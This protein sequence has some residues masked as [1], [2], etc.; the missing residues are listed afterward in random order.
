MKK[1]GG[2]STYALL[3]IVTFLLTM[4]SVVIGTPLFRLIRN[5][6]GWL[7]YWGLGL[8]YCVLLSVV[9]AYPYTI[10]FSILW[11]TIGIYHELEVQG[12]TWK[13][14]SIL[15]LLGGIFLGLMLPVLLLNKL[16]L[17]TFSQFQD[18]FDQIYASLKNINP[19]IKIE[20]E[21]FIN[22]FPAILIDLQIIALATSVMFEKR[23][24]QLFKIPRVRTVAQVNLLEFRI[25]DFL[26]WFVLFG[27][28]LSFQDFGKQELSIIGINIVNIGIVLYF[29]QGLA[30]VEVFLI[31]IR[32]GAFFRAVLYFFVVGNLFFLISLIGFVDFWLDF[33]RRLIRIQKSKTN[34]N[35][36]NF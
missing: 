34:K 9:G 7:G 36:G 14:A 6:Y 28:L 16:E 11:I 12:K 32:A 22:N 5:Q 25:P 18:F 29:L 26:I 31:A 27:F 2:L 4:F 17:F 8:F 1:V 24:H 15:S 33:R 3:A 23:V 19:G 10:L 21:L 20:K 13:T 30:V 35:E